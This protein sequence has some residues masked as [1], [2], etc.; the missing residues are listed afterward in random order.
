M[1]L[2]SVWLLGDLETEAK[3]IRLDEENLR[4]GV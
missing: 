1:F 4:L 2:E 3:M